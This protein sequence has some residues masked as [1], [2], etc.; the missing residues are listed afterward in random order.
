MWNFGKQSL[1][2]VP[3]WH[4]ASRHHGVTSTNDQHQLCWLVSIVKW[5]QLSLWRKL[6]SLQRIFQVFCYLN[7]DSVLIMYQNHR[8][9][10]E[11]L[12]PLHCRA[13]PVELLTTK[14]FESWFD[15]LIWFSCLALQNS[16][17]YFVGVDG[18][19]LTVKYQGTSVPYCEGNRVCFGFW[20]YIS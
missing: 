6:L 13:W 5:C 2:D 7:I 14:H 4:C 17:Y 18:L 19:S 1:S 9:F 10:K 12:L 8:D 3:V 11:L 16:C 15:R 20:G